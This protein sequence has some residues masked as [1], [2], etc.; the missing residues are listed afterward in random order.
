M[1]GMWFLSSFLGNILSGYVGL[2]YEKEILSKAGFFWL[3]TGL[4]VATGFAIWAFAKPL[5]KA[6]VPS[7]GGWPGHCPECCHATS[8]AGDWLFRPRQGT[9]SRHYPVLRYY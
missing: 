5:K 7:R 9:I 2:L 4:G 6:M 8:V 1:M 3:L